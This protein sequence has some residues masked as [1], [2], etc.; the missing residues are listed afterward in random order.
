MLPRQLGSVSVEVAEVLED[1][2]LKLKKEFN[3]KAME[4]LK[5]KGESGVAYKVR[6]RKTC[7]AGGLVS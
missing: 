3:K 4:G 6:R 5:A 2:K 7:F 1:G